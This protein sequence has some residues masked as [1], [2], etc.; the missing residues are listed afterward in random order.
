MAENRYNEEII[1]FSGL[2]GAA[3]DNVFLLSKFLG[4]QEVLIFCKNLGV[5]LGLPP[6]PAAFQFFSD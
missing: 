2:S 5:L 1:P 6:A 4:P 3:L